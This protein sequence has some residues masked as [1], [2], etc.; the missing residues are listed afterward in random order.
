MAHDYLVQ[1]WLDGKAGTWQRISA[2]SELEAAELVTGIKLR[3][4]GKLGELR[5]RVRVVGNLNKE[6]AFYASLQ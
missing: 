3:I 4:V 5:A 2:N 6:T 1:K